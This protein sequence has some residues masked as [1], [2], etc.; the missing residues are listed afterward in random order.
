MKVQL[1]GL[2]H[3]HSGLARGAARLARLWLG[4]LLLALVLGPWLGA[5]HRTVHGPSAQAPGHASVEW[6]DAFG[7]HDRAIDCLA[8]DQLS[9][10]HAPPAA[11]VCLLPQPCVAVPAWSC[12]A[13]LPTR[14]L[15]AFRARAP[16]DQIA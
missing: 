16:P 8:Y 6:D 5:L 13:R 1:A 12:L 7:R 14:V 4:A 2:G 9:H 11:A 10:G 15:A 3:R